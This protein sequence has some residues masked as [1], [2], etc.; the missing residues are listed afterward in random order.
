[1]QTAAI[2]AA[3]DAAGASGNGGRVVVPAGVWRA[4]TVWLRSTCHGI[5]SGPSRWGGSRTSA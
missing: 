3:I 4:G 1:M 5:S 2:Q